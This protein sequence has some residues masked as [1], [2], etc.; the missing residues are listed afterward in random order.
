[1]QLEEGQGDKIMDALEQQP[2]I[3]G[4]RMVWIDGLRAEFERGWGLVRA[5]NT[6]PSLVFRFEADDAQAL[7]VVQDVFRTLMQKVAPELEM[8]F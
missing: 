1:M 5:S 6:T 8:P 2:E 4:A 3:P 7:K